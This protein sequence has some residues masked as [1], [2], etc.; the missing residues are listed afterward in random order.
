MRRGLR[1][2]ETL[3]I[4]AGA[5]A[6]VWA[7]VVWRWQDPFTYLLAEREQRALSSQYER[8]LAEFDRPSP[9]RRSLIALQEDFRRRVR[10]TLPG[11]DLPALGSDR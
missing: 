6:L 3:L 4:V 9:R 1:W 5:G 10:V 7:L 11:E 8:R 2:S